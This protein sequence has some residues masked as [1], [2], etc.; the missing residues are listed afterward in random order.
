[1][2]TLR[3]LDP[4]Q[5]WE[6]RPRGAAAAGSRPA[7]ET[8]APRSRPAVRTAGT[9]ERRPARSRHRVSA[10][11]PERPGRRG[12]GR[13]EAR[14]GAAAG[15][16]RASWRGARPLPP[17]RGHGSP[18][19]GARAAAELGR[20]VGKGLSGRGRLA[21]AP[22]ALDTP[23]ARAEPSSAGPL[24]REAPGAPRPFSEARHA[25]LCPSLGRDLN[26]CF[27]KSCFPD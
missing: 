8:R 9:R 13:G 22:T 10:G 2:Q 12:W 25:E 1:M 18:G 23:W 24:R 20:R 16:P 14:P 27:W 3:P 7:G 19:P 17:G 21:P 5:P 4:A 15:P 26:L 11:G 6:P